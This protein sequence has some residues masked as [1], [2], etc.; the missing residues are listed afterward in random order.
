MPSVC[1][2][3]L[4]RSL[5]RQCRQKRYSG[6]S[7]S[8][9][10]V[11]T[12]KA[13]N[14]SPTG[15]VASDKRLSTLTLAVLSTAPGAHHCRICNRCISHMDHHCPWMNNCVRRLGYGC[16]LC[17]GGRGWCLFICIRPYLTC[18]FRFPPSLS[19][20]RRQSQYVSSAVRTSQAT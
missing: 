8:M 5:P 11:V 18:L 13:I 10:C 20:W 19:D 3:I 7:A 4:V 6:Q 12:A 9:P 1:L 17:F 16:K 15:N 2:Q 14:V